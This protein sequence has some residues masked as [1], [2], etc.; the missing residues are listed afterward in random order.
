MKFNFGTGIFIF[1]A[2]FM[3]AMISFVIFAHRQDANLVHKD[4]YE[5]GVDYSRQMEKEKRSAGY[6]E[7]IEISD[8]GSVVTI[9]FAG[10][11]LPLLGQGTVNFFRPSDYKKDI[12]FPLKL[13]GNVFVA[14]KDKL[15][16]GRYIVKITW[17]ADNLEYEVDKTLIVK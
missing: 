12:S 2:L 6:S 13:T 9:R 11:L 15:I 8:N 10:E 17:I 4:Y 1:L 3:T 14:E 7:M 16:H 5:K